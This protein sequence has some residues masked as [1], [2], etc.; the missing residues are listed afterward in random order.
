LTVSYVRTARSFARSSR[1]ILR[2]GVGDVRREHVS[3]NRLRLHFF[4]QLATALPSNERDI[5]EQ[6]RPFGRKDTCLLS[7]LLI[8]SSAR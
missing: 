6:F 4:K 7:S 3:L 1:D 5:A 8:Q 2:M